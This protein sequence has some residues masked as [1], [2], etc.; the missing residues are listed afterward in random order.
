M[1]GLDPAEWLELEQ[2]LEHRRGPAWSGHGTKHDAQ[3]GLHRMRLRWRGG[4]Y[5]ALAGLRKPTGST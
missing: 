2:L 4:A 3:E 1:A 5:S